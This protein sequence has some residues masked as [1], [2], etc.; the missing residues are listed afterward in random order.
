M[1]GLYRLHLAR[2]LVASEPIVSGSSV[3]LRNIERHL[4]EFDVTVLERS[5][6]SRTAVSVIIPAYNAAAYIEEA[7]ES[8]LHQ[9]YAEIETI[10]VDDGSTDG[11]AKILERYSDRIQT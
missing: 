2:L 3:D 10:V 6:M 1:G 9:T 8:V 4:C 7:V 5:R 11:T